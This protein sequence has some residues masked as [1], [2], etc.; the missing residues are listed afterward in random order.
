MCVRCLPSADDGTSA[1]SRSCSGWSHFFPG[2]SRSSR[3]AP[4]WWGA[5]AG[6]RGAEKHRFVAGV[7]TGAGAGV[8]PVPAEFPSRV[9]SGRRRLSGNESESPGDPMRLARALR[10]KRAHP[11]LLPAQPPLP[12]AWGAPSLRVPHH[13]GVPVLPTR[14]SRW[15]GTVPCLGGCQGSRSPGAAAR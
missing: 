9:S 7:C 10:Q 13:P 6:R 14:G 12:A 5:L 11:E 2:L 4:G 1:G 8:V 3:A 15:V